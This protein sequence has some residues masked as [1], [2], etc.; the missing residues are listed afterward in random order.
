MKK[1]IAVLTLSLSLAGC[2]SG[3][4][5][6]LKFVENTLSLPKGVLTS[7]VSNPVTPYMLYEIENGLIPVVAGLN[8]YKRNCWASVPKGTPAACK[9]TTRKLQAY[10]RRIVPL[11]NQA[12]DFVT[13]NDQVNAR[14][15]YGEIMKLVANFK[16]T[17]T[18]AGVKS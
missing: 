2:A 7:S 12:K 1:I 16:N 8:I 10:T 5:I 17:A 9:N 6:G 3:A 18:L 15:A 13:K 11:L 14:I 4:D